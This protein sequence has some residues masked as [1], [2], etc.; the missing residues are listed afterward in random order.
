[1]TFASNEDLGFESWLHDLSIIYF[2][3]FNWISKIDNFWA[4][5]KNKK[6]NSFNCYNLVIHAITLTKKNLIDY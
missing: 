5:R 1:M 4:P 3:I 6:N 2:G